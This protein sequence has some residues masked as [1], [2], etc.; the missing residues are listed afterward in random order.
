MTVEEIYQSRRELNQMA[1]REREDGPEQYGG[2][3]DNQTNATE[4]A[5]RYQ[6]RFNQNS[7]PRGH[8][9][10]G[11]DINKVENC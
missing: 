11:K 3:T 10:L 1:N 8:N 9:G 4:R 2:T 5:L 6:D 7:E